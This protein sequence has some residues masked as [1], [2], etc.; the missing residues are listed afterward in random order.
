ME[1]LNT[2][3]KHI[4]WWEK[5]ISEPVTGKNAVLQAISNI[6]DPVYIIS[7][8]GN[9]SVVQDGIASI[10][11]KETKEIKGFPLLAYAPPLLPEDLGDPVF[12]KRYNLRF[13]YIVGAMANGITSTEMVEAAGRAGMLGFF[14]SGGLTIPEIEKA[15]HD[16]KRRLDTFPFGLN[17]IHS[18]N[19]PEFELETVRLYLKHQV[20][21]ISASAYLELTLPLVYFRIK[22]I[23]RNTQGEIVC[24]NKIIAK[25]SRIEVASKFLSPPPEK[26]ISQLIEKKMISPEE[27]SLAEHISMADDIT[28]EAD[29]GGHTDNRPAISLLPTMIALRNNFTNKYNYSKP[30]GVGLG[31]GI[32]TPESA[33]AAFALGASYVLTGSINQSC[34]E[35][36]TSETVRQM[37]AQAKQADVVM[38]PSGDMFE[39]GVKVQV[40]KRGTM[41]PMRASKLYDIF[42]KHDNFENIPDDQ[43]EFVEKKLLRCSFEKEWEQTKKFFAGIDPKQ[44]DI[45]EKHPKHKMALIFRSY[46]GRASTWAN[47]GD[48]SRTI[49]YQIWCGPSMGAF[50]EWVKGSF[51]E[52]Y[53]NRKIV[54]VA[55]NLLYGASITTRAGW[56]RT[57]A[58]ELPANAASFTPIKDQKIWEFIGK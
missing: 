12:K 31:G 46:L 52:D 14:G 32:A 38:A 9:L 28:A 27:A 48:P 36:G 13:A 56:L 53:K 39:L 22:G 10:G 26:L 17:L 43:K 21:L 4:G 49:D 45:G 3:N 1:S 57:Q 15:I 41:F 23:Y 2:Q 18:H 40:L 33:A 55:L 20:S 8:N 35:A 34:T 37:L 44:I 25:V 11:S 29:S 47:T 54:T 58:I 5:S 42:T 6:K 16:L 7:K 50:N 24:P 30:I 51:L 19:S